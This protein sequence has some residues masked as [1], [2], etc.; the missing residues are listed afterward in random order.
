MTGTHALK[1]ATCGKR[2]NLGGRVLL[3]KTVINLLENSCLCDKPNVKK[4]L[5]EYARQQKAVAT[6]LRDIVRRLEQ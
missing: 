3:M 5:E 2:V 4:Q 6:A 1:C